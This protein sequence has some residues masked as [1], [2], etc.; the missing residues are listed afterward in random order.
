MSS[1]DETTDY[2]QKVS[3]GEIDA[4]RF[5]RLACE[6]HLRDLEKDWRYHFDPVSADKF[7]KFCR[8]LKH[9]K[10]ESAGKTFELEAWQKFI[11]GNIYGWLDEDNNWRF[12]TAYIEIPRKNGKT[13]MASAGA[14]YD[15]AFVDRT[16]AE[17]YCVATK[18]DQ[19]KLLFNDCVAYINQSQE[20]GSIFSNL[21]GRSI[22][23]VGDTAR[24]SFIKP[25]GSDSKRLDGLNPLSV[26]CDELHAWKKRDLWDVMEDAF[27]ARKQYHMVAITTAGHNREGICYEERKHLVR[28]L[29]Q[30]IDAED[31]FGVIHTVDDEDQFN[32]KEERVWKIANPNLGIGKEVEYMETQ[33]QKVAQVPSKLNT[34]LNKQLNIWTD[35]E[36]AWIQTEAWN[37]CASDLCEDDLI[38]KVC[39]GGMDL[40]RVNDLSA[41]GYFFPKQKGLEKNVLLV[42]FFVPDFELRQREERDL[43]PYRLWADKH[44]LTLTNGKTTDWDYIK[45]SILKRN[46]QFVIEAFG[47][48]R[49][50]AGELVNSLQKEN[51]EMTP[52]GMGYISMSSPTA[53][54]ERQIIAGEIQHIGCPVLTWNIANT[55]VKQD[56]AGNLKPDKARSVDRIDGTVASIIALGMSMRVDEKKKSPYA[57]RGMRVL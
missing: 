37:A 15:S 30:Q 35:V 10:G 34:F 25:L 33:A 51:V 53:E 9:Y 48:D 39:F 52:F 50:F 57:E 29:E 6:R 36:Q 28:V 24:T 1:L 20:V 5:V 12:K 47:Y 21:I 7:F 49:H 45:E 56:P 23:Y 42:D 18:E 19:A 38:G 16:G 4:C 2:A 22:L 46:G 3:S 40:A 17:V 32:W 44:S 31:K 55:I 26:Y 54:F 41:C 13:T 43:V 14:L 27:G 11:F 8:Y